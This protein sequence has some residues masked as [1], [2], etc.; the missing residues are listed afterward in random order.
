MSDAAGMRIHLERCAAVT[1]T[2]HTTWVF[3]VL[4]D[5][6][7]T[8]TTVEVTSGRTEQ[9]MGALAGMVETLSGADGVGEGQ[10]ERLLGLAR[11]RLRTEVV[12]ATAVSALRSALAQLAA[13]RAGVSLHRSLG[14]ETAGAVELYAN[15]NR[16]LHATD[17]TP[18]AFERA[19]TRAAREGFATFK[20]APFDEVSPAMAPDRMLRSAEP[21][22]ERVRAVRRAVGPDARVLVDCHSRFSA[23]AAPAVA[24]ELATLDVGWFEEP[25]QPTSASADLAAIAGAAPLPVAGGESGYGVEFFDGLLDQRAVTVVMPDVKYCGGVAEAVRAGGSAVRRGGGVSLHS[26]SGP[27]SLLASAHVTAAVDGAMPL[28]H[29]LHEVDWRADL[30]EPAEWIE[31][32][33]LLLPSSAGLG[34]ALNEKVVRRHGRLWRP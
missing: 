19:A 22:I 2:P 32:G 15:I 33:R 20:C 27:V 16:G 26:P 17:R 5:G 9:V 1:A 25:V 14:A 12:L 23:E 13:A 3:A 34:A 8:A 21:G 6:E 4:G 18:G 30:I 10:V 28:E 31:G 7:G 29:A 24:R 11:H